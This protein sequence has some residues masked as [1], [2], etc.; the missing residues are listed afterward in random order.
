MITRNVWLRCVK[1]VKRKEIVLIIGARQVG[2]TTLL[3]QIK[4]KLDAEHQIV[5]FFSLE[6]P[7]LLNLLNQKPEN[8][9]SYISKTKKKQYLLIDEIQYLEKASGFL[10]YIYDIYGEKIKLIVTGSSA[11]YVDKSF[12]DSLAGRKRIIELFPFSF[13]EFIKAKEAT[14]SSPLSEKIISET[15]C[16]TG[17]KRN[18]LVPEKEKLWNYLEEYLLY[19]GYPSVILEPDTKEKCII[20]K[21]LYVSFLKKDILEA[22]VSDTHKFYQLVRIL[23][24]GAGSLFNAS[25]IGNTIGLSPDTVREYLHILRKSYIFSLVVPYFSNLRKELTKMPKAYLLDGGFRNAVLNTFENPQE[26]LDK[27]AFLE[28]Q[29]LIALHTYGFEK[30]NFWRTQD[31]NEV[32]FVID[33][34][35]ALEVK[36][37]K[38]AYNP[39]KYEKFTGSYPHIPLTP[40]FF[41][42]D[43][44]IDLLDIMH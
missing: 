23:S 2:K 9:F 13:S 8:I 36:W 22:G 20:L 41:R 32:D 30:I 27:G 15:W 37:Q 17:R 3:K 42:D 6:D 44:N 5:N 10:K 26:R 34:N 28:N 40:V 11:F 16:K 7:T 38:A 25:E 29:V 4:K 24:E 14:N 31:K 39:K 19:G 12:N 21:D 18:L 43:T 1:Y 35:H 33:G